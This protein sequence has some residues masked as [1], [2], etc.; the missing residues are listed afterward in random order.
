MDKFAELSMDGWYVVVVCFMLSRMGWGVLET[1][2]ELGRSAQAGTCL[3]GSH[4]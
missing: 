1:S 3:S 2:A 4:Y